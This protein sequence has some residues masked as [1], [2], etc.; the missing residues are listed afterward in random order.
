MD[1][2]HAMSVFVAVAEEESFAAA[3]RRLNLSPPAVTRTIAALEAH[4]GIQLLTRTTRFVRA[5][6]AGLRY[7]ESARRL[8]AEADEADEAAAGIHATPRGQLTVTAPV[9][10]GAMHVMPGIVD[11]LSRYPAVT[12]SA[13]FLDRVVNLLEEGMDVGIRIGEL[14]DSTMR[15]IAVGSVKRV[16]CAAPAYL[17]AHPQP[18]EPRDLAGHT[19]ISASTASPGLE[20]RLGAS[21][22][23]S[24]KIQP[25]LTA[26]TNAAAIEAARQGLGITRLM[27]YQVAAELADGRL[28]RLL[29]DWESAP[30][31]VHI[32]HQEG[33]QASAKVRA[34]VDVLAQHLRGNPA[35]SAH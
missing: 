14:P 7:L 25:R 27:S 22:P 3:A 17:A 30:L 28:V 10:F 26:N 34:L 20:W 12:V 32:V 18:L 1:R 33:R 24:V 8:L 16:I 4:V 31:P 5:T 19:I 2:L 6:D 23:V 11:F 21:Q 9:L 15:A 13:V 35:L 29:P